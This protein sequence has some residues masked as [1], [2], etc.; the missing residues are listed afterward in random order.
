[1]SLLQ[2][3]LS[4]SAY[5]FDLSAD[6]LGYEIIDSV[7]REMTSEQLIAYV[8]PEND[9]QKRSFFE[10]ILDA[11]KDKEFAV[12]VFDWKEQHIVFH[13]MYRLCPAES[14]M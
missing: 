8:V 7:K 10:K 12:K 5:D 14:C 13:G 1:M 9:T 4:C 6:A 2:T 11:P 3:E